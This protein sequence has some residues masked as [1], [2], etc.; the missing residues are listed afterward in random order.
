MLILAA[1]IKDINALDFMN[2]EDEDDHGNFIHNNIR[3]E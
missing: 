1:K 3:E 2:T